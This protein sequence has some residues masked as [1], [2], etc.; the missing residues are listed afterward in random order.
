MMLM[1][2]GEQGGSLI[3]IWIGTPARIV[4]TLRSIR[5]VTYGRGQQIDW[6]WTELIEFD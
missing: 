2:W 3:K 1:L 4:A 6:N 5:Y